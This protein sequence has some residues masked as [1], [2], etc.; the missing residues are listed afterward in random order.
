MIAASLFKKRILYCLNIAWDLNLIC[1]QHLFSIIN[2]VSVVTIFQSR[3]WQFYLSEIWSNKPCILRGQVCSSLAPVS[4]RFATVL[5]SLA[6]KNELNHIILTCVLYKFTAHVFLVDF[7]GTFLLFHKLQQ[8][9]N[10]PH[11]VRFRL[12]N[13]F[14]FI[15][16]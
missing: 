5:S 4:Y 6:D 9:W 3:N 1:V 16:I 11:P 8:K 13:K 15:P 2:G 7:L 10:I 14:I 12:W